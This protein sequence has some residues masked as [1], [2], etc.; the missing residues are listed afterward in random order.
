MLGFHKHKHIGAISVSISSSFCYF[1]FFLSS[2]LILLL[3]FVLITWAFCPWRP[4]NGRF[5]L[6]KPTSGYFFWCVFSL[7]VLAIFCFLLFGVSV[8]G[9]SRYSPSSFLQTFLKVWI[10][11]W[12]RECTLL[13][14][15]V[16]ST[17]CTRDVRSFNDSL[18]LL[19]M[20]L[21]LL[22]FLWRSSDIFGWAFVTLREYG[23]SA[24]IA[25]YWSTWRR[26]GTFNNL[27]VVV[28]NA[29]VYAIKRWIF[30]IPGELI[31]TPVWYVVEDH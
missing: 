24:C 22:C 8:T 2:I 18:Q 5:I 29:V 7:L 19:L 21:R 9:L 23:F 6:A 25:I 15:F 12:S 1:I 3:R 11:S 27:A 16:S 10:H 30:V 20:V 14:Q 28:H 13:R 31:E 26:G 4:E 17:M